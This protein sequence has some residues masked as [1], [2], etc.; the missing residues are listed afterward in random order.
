MS[1]GE[2]V[3]DA[4]LYW[5]LDLIEP[6]IVSFWLTAFEVARHPVLVARLGD[7]CWL[8]RAAERPDLPARS[9]LRAFVQLA[10]RWE[11][12]PATTCLRRA[13]ALATVFGDGD[14]LRQIYE[15]ATGGFDRCIDQSD[16]PG[17]S[18]RYLRLLASLRRGDHSIDLNPY[19][20]KAKG[21]LGENP[22][23][24]EDIVDLERGLLGNDPA[25]HSALRREAAEG[26]F[27][28]AQNVSGINSLYLLQKAKAIANDMPD[29]RD[30]LLKF[31]R[32]FDPAS[33]EWRRGE[34]PL[35]EIVPHYEAL[36][37][38]L[39]DAPD[40]KTAL[41]RWIELGSPT[42]DSK[43]N[44]A[45]ARRIRAN[46][47]LGEFA[48]Q[49]V[50]NASTRQARAVETD[51]QRLERE[52]SE[53]ELFY[54]HIN[55]ELIGAPFLRTFPRWHEPTREEMQAW[56]CGSGAPEDAVQAFV[57]AVFDYWGASDYLPCALAVAA[58]VEALVR[59]R[60]E[61]C[62]IV[63]TSNALDSSRGGVKTLGDLI[64]ALEGHIDECWRRFLRIALVKDNGANL[65]NELFHGLLLRPSESVVVTLV[66]AALYLCLLPEPP[67]QRGPPLAA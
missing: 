37:R 64:A 21:V 1:D 29:L 19:F 59:H 16:K 53:I 41:I 51:E 11:G 18:M 17:I 27:H 61:Q 66:L 13:M 39:Y 62:G 22:C 52:V 30:E 48:T 24:L 57:R 7:L 35:D 23:I 10:Q 25:R 54:L 46:S 31:E 42:R 32:A 38:P 40:W 6:P 44:I 47:L 33:I 14:A 2:R 28:A 12:L 4:E 15:I 3:S 43:Q 55:L 65:R 63:V 60:A 67:I 56:L 26:Y 20:A 45:L 50:V 49:I 34:I 5:G 9:A 58:A 36:S 8:K